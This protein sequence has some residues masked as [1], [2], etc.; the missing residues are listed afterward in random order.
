MT[1]HLDYII[2]TNEQDKAKKLSELE[3]KLFGKEDDSSATATAPAAAAHAGSSNGEASRRVDGGEK[4]TA[5]A[6]AAAA[7]V[8]AAPVH[9]AQ[10]AFGG[11]G[12]DD[13]GG[14]GGPGGPG[15]R[16]G[17]MNGSARR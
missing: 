1:G 7:A 3:K 14:G 17:Q 4:P 12:D 15:P 6:V 10:P 8:S 16:N 2:L 11:F 13:S 5:T 9:P